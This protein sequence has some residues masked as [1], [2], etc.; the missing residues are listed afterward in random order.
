[1]F[2]AGGKNPAPPANGTAY[3]EADWN[4]T[5][6]LPGEAYHISKV[7]GRCEKRHLTSYCNAVGV[8]KWV[9]WRRLHFFNYLLCCFMHVGQADTSATRMIADL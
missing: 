2:A 9:F 7:S 6:E 5:S 8:H 4:R 3:T 1:V